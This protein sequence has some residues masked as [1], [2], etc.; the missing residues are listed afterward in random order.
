MPGNLHGPAASLRLLAGRARQALA[1]ASILTSILTS[2]AGCTMTDAAV[3]KDTF[4]RKIDALLAGKDS[5]VVQASALTDFGWQSLCFERDD[6]LLLRF[7][8]TDAGDRLLSLPYEEFFV[9]EGHVAGSLED[10]CVA[11]GDRIVVRKKYPGYQGPIEFQKA[12]QG[13]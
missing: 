1:A 8:G 3:S 13:G 11:P 9:D 6:T 4:A 12:P 5:A 7:K 2:L 10:E